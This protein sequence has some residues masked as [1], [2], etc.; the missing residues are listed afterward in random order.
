MTDADVKTL[1]DEVRAQMNKALDHFENELAKIRAGARVH[2][3]SM[4]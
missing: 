4:V 3:C 1:L 2:L